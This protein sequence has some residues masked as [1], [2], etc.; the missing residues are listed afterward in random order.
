M[1]FIKGYQ[2]G[3]DT[4]TDSDSELQVKSSESV[5]ISEFASTAR[6]ESKNNSENLDFFSLKN[7][8]RPCVDHSDSFISKRITPAKES[9]AS[10]VVEKS[11]YVV[12][13]ESNF[14]ASQSQKLDIQ[15]LHKLGHRMNDGPIQIVEIDQSQRLKE[16]RNQS[17]SAN[18]ILPAKDTRTR[19]TIFSL[20]SKATEDHG[21][22]ESRKS[23]LEATRQLSKKR[24]GF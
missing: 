10:E 22:M 8:K 13:G 1:D 19:H 9:L 6:M 2:S 20:A 12:T 24:Y 4:E 3:S 14:G 16:F 18:H 15:E 5:K 17:H 11:P 7:L 23:H 21:I